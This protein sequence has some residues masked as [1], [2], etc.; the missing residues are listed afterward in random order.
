MGLLA[1]YL[2]V[3]VVV[4]REDYGWFI[5]WPMPVCHFT[6]SR[7]MPFTTRSQ[8]QGAALQ[9][10]LSLPFPPLL[11]YFADRLSTLYFQGIQPPNPPSYTF[12]T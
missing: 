8:V 10:F 6:F 12:R 4:S 9:H 1:K 5:D 3:R 2:R 7:D 11:F